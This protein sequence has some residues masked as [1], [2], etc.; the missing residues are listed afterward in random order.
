MSFKSEVK[1]RGNDRW[2]ERSWWLWWG[3]PTTLRSQV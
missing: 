2:W 1:D 3:F